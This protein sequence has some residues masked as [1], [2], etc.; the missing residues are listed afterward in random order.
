MADE[1]ND[2][3]HTYTAWDDDGNVVEQRPYTEQELASLA[4]RQAAAAALAQRESDRAAVKSIIT[5]LQAEKA[6]VQVVL[7]KTTAQ[8]TLAD[9]KDVARA[10]KRIADA[11]IDLS[12]FVKDL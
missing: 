2:V 9:T 6:R 1:M 8:L 11:A 5:D 7:D 12:R 10:A 3:T 4:E